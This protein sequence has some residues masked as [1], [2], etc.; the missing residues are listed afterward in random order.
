MVGNGPVQ[1]IDTVSPSGSLTCPRRKTRAPAG[2]VATAV[3]SAPASTTGAPLGPPPPGTTSR[4]SVSLPV[5][6]PPSLT[7]SVRPGRRRGG[8]TTLDCTSCGSNT[9]GAPPSIRQG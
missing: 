1:V 9:I 6:P 7:A 3:K 2:D 5:A 4:I 8:G